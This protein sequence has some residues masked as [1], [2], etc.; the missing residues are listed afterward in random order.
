MS[1]VSV[2]YAEGL[3][4]LAKETDSV[5]K[6][7]TETDEIRRCFNTVENLKEFFESARI[8]K[9][10]KKKLVDDVLKDKY[11]RYVVNFI[12]LLIDKDRINIYEDICKDFR[13]L[14]NDE[15]NCREGIIESAREL[16]DD[17]IEELEK[18]LSSKD[19]KVELIPRINKSLISGFRIIFDDQVIDNSMKN[20]IRQLNETLIRKDGGSWN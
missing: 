10:A 6:F 11:D 3:F 7:K 15:L 16:T 18:S 5:Q 4:E 12:K 1:L 17:Q 2:N 19:R 8:S 13:K 14:C 9:T 20:K